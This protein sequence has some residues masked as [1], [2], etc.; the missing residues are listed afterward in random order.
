MK[1]LIL[2]TALL[3][4]MVRCSDSKSR[5]QYEAK[6]KTFLREIA[7]DSTIR[8]YV[9]FHGEDVL[10]KF[11]SGK[12]YGVVFF[13]PDR[14]GYRFIALIHKSPNGVVSYYFDEDSE[15]KSVMMQVTPDKNFPN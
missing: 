12:P 4:V 2:L 15:G 7:L 11:I 10:V 6:R 14:K 8:R 13:A 5:I 3:A 1:K 9:G